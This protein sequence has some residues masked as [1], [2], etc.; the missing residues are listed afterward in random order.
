MKEAIS[1]L[2]DGETDDVERQRTLSALRDDPALRAAWERYHLTGSVLRRE[3]DVLVGPGLADRIHQRLAAEVPQPPRRAGWRY[4]R[5]GAGMAIAAT[6][7]AVAIVNLRPVLSPAGLEAKAVPAAGSAGTQVA[8][9]KPL[10]P[11]K[12]QALNP[13]LVQHGEF[14]PAAG[15]NGMSSYVRVVGRQDGGTEPSGAE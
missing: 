2:V 11:D 4:F 6:V 3:L 12:Q 15:M 10:P 13:Y 7:A 14:T 5:L 9:V 8:E 1:A